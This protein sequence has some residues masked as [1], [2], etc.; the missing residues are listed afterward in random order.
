MPLIPCR[1][2]ALLTTEAKAAGFTL[3]QEGLDTIDLAV[4]NYESAA[5]Q[6]NYSSLGSFLAALYGKGMNEKIFVE[7]MTDYLTAS[8]YAN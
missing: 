4:A 8:Y 5:G 1:E 2:V 7:D 6:N 3:P